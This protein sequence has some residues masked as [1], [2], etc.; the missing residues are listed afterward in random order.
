MQRKF[1]YCFCIKSCPL[2]LNCLIGRTRQIENFIIV[3]PLLMLNIIFFPPIVDI[4]IISLHNVLA[5]WD[6]SNQSFSL[7]NF[8]ANDGEIEALQSTREGLVVVDDISELIV[9]HNASSTHEHLEQQNTVLPDAGITLSAWISISQ[10]TRGFSGLVAAATAGPGCNGG[11][12]LGYSMQPTLTVLQFNIALPNKHG[13]VSAAEA[14]FSIASI[15]L[16]RLEEGV[17]YHVAA[18]YDGSKQ[19]LYLDG[20]LQHAHLACEMGSNCGHIVYPTVSNAASCTNPIALTLGSYIN[21]GSGDVSPHR[22]FLKEVSIFALALTSEQI[23]AKFLLLQAQMKASPVT[24]NEYWVQKMRQSSDAGAER[25]SRIP[26]DE[27][28]HNLLSPSQDFAL[29]SASTNISVLGQFATLAKY[30]CRFTNDRFQKDSKQI[31][32]SFAVLSCSACSCPSGYQDTLTCPTPPWKTSA[33]DAAAI[34]SV[35]KH[36][37]WETSGTHDSMDLPYHKSRENKIW[38]R[39]CMYSACGFVDI[40][41]RGDVFSSCTPWWLTSLLASTNNHSAPT[42]YLS[43]LLVGTKSVIRFVSNSMMFSANAS[44]LDI[45]TRRDVVHAR[46]ENQTQTLVSFEQMPTHGVYSTTFFHSDDTEGNRHFFITFANFW[47]FSASFRR[48]SS[49]F[50]IAP[51]AVNKTSD[52]R[53]NNGSI[54]SDDAHRYKNFELDLVQQIETNGARK[55]VHF[56]HGS[57]RNT[58]RAIEYLAV[59]NFFGSSSLHLWSPFDDTSNGAEVCK[60]KAGEDSHHPAC[61]ADE[62]SCDCS[63]NCNDFED[64]SGHGRCHGI[65]GACICDDSWGG[66]S[67]DTRGGLNRT[68]R[69]NNQVQIPTTCATDVAVFNLSEHIT[70]LVFSVFSDPLCMPP[71]ASQD[72]AVPLSSGSQIYSIGTGLSLVQSL[73]NVTAARQVSVF[74]S[75]EKMFLAF[76]GE[77]EESAVV[78]VASLASEPP[79]FVRLQTLPLS[80]SMSVSTFVWGGRY[81][82][83]SG[84]ASSSLLLRWDGGRFH[85]PTDMLTLPRNTAG[86]QVLPFNGSTGTLHFSVPLHLDGKEASA[87]GDGRAHMV[88]LGGGAGVQVARGTRERVQG[89]KRPVEI[90]ISSDGRFVYV[91]AQESR[92]IASFE[93]DAASGLLTYSP[94][95]SY[96]TDWTRDLANGEFV[97]DARVLGTGRGYPLRGVSALKISSDSTSSMVVVTSVLDSCVTVFSRDYVTGSLKIHIVIQ[98]GDVLAGKVVDGLAGARSLAISADTGRL[99]VVGWLD[100][101]VCAF[102]RSASGDFTYLGRVNDTCD[103]QIRLCMPTKDEQPATD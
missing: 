60:R 64:C 65:T 29:T 12:V 44:G 21:V 39:T 4:L 76:A 89:L 98:D 74:K 81:L 17:W 82:L 62:F 48:T 69:L 34:L 58:T 71:E 26:A 57:L 86:G 3:F 25:G 45:A 103:L 55:I 52:G 6:Q 70:Y 92:S 7:L 33:K 28:G 47:D 11:F 42:L 36:A 40:Y 101:A 87:S 54:P 20:K 61:N 93:R 85:G 88:L 99:F 59:V 18:T 37:D 43:P 50:R 80:S 66:Q 56:V 14:E 38:Q 78:Y 90:Q 27:L 5:E 84:A 10:G 83:L 72:P 51:S 31:F 16:P 91:A 79:L 35:I 8:L 13:I 9:K 41:L 53:Q 75:H 77:G 19:S 67:C 32:N 23:E 95:A 97:S 68:Q 73:W 46:S 63:E 30:S 2:E 49:I 15:A 1:G 24:L 102:G 22:G 96:N 100:Q 94:T